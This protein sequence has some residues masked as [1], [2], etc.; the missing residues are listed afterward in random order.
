MEEL[1][2]RCADGFDLTSGCSCARVFALQVVGE[3]SEHYDYTLRGKP[4]P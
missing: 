4:A 2:S 1:Y 3:R